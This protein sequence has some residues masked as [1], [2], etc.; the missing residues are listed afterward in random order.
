[1]KKSIRKKLESL[2][3]FNE[4]TW[5][6]HYEARSEIKP[7]VNGIACPECMA[8]LVDDFSVILNSVGTV[9]TNPE[10]VAIRCKTCDFF[11][12]RYYTS[13]KSS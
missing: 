9:P 13:G 12:W 10:M 7:R 1:M 11:S 3:C 5:K 2:S 6:A 8:E 4:R